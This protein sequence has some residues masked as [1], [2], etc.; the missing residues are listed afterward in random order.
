MWL[1]MELA[2]LAA[3]LVGVGIVLV[4][5]LAAHH[6]TVTMPR[7]RRALKAQRRTQAPR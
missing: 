2:N 3:I 4:L 6:V 7:R 5:V 1:L